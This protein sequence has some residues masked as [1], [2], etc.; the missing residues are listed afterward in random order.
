MDTQSRVRDTEKEGGHIG[1]AGKNKN[2]RLQICVDRQ[3][4]IYR[5]FH[6]EC[7]KVN[8]Y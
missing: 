7:Y 8:E 5:V 1:G 2:K 3:S 6:R 4:D